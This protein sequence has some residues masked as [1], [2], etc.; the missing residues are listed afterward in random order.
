MSA[1]SDVIIVGS[2]PAGAMSAWGL[3]GRTICMLDVGHTPEAAGRLTDNLYRLR[4]RQD[5][6]SA[7]IGEHFEGLRN[8]RSLPISAKLKAPGMDF[9]TRDWQT[10]TGLA[11]ESFQPVISLAY[12]GFGNAWGAGV[13]RFTQRDLEGFPLR[14]EDLSPYY[15][16][17]SRHIGISGVVDDLDADFG[18][19]PALDPPL[20]LSRNCAGLLRSYERERVPLNRAGVRLGRSRLAVITKPRDGRE[21]YA[22][23]ALEFAQPG[24]PAVYN[25]SL[26]LNKLR[27]DQ[28]VNYLPGWV[29]QRF[30]ETKSYIEVE[31]RRPSGETAAFRARCLILAAGALNSARI[32]L[33]SAGDHDTRLPLLDNPMTVLPVFHPRNFG[34]AL[35]PS[36]SC[37]AQLN[38]VLDASGRTYQASLYGLNG[39]PVAEF[40][41]RLPF[42]LPDNLALLKHLLPALSIT[43]LFYPADPSPGQ[44]LRLRPD[45]VL[46]AA[47]SWRPDPG[48]TSELARILRRLGGWTVAQLAQHPAP[49]NG[50]HYAGTLPMRAVPG[51]HELHPDGRLQGTRSV[52]VSDGSAFPRLPAKNLTYTIMANALRIAEGVREGLG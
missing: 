2:G 23:R 39:A 18:H 5:L 35:D 12:G 45:G 34:R 29:V 14:L 8:L 51:R 1:T 4:R 13:Y 7:F 42:S 11:S 22:Y 9:I 37:L 28:A 25:P 3:R 41:S 26:T 17:V 19:E 6:T 20:R 15:D 40:L 30:R 33:A 50:I 10:L 48:I 36:D 32:V 52:Y 24:D 46:D 47:Y 16:A 21:P 43:M 38:L 44:F 27:L 49:G 31:A